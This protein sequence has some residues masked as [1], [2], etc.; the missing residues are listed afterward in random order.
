MPQHAMEKGQPFQSLQRMID[1][2][3]WALL[4]AHYILPGTWDQRPF[5]GAGAR[6]RCKQLPFMARIAPFLELRRSVKTL[7]S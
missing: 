4:S 3:V 5:S 1:S 2:N 7:R 6:Q